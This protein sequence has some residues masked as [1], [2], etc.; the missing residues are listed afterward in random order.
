M[1]IWRRFAMWACSSLC[2]REI[3]AEAARMAR[4]R[5]AEVDWLKRE[6]ARRTCP[7]KVRDAAQAKLDELAGES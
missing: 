5:D 3:A 2:A 6:A 1:G 7:V 4:Q